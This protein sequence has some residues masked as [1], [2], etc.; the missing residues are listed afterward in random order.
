MKLLG[1][2]NLDDPLSSKPVFY[3]PDPSFVDVCFVEIVLRVDLQS[4]G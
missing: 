3:V 1:L 2:K 4:S